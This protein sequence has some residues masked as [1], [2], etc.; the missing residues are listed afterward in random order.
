MKWYLKCLRQFANFRGRARRKEFWMF[1]LFNV[2]ITLLYLLLNDL[3]S[4]FLEDTK[5]GV[6]LFDILRIIYLAYLVV[7]FT[8]SLAVT[9]RRLHDVGKSGW[10]ILIIL[11]PIYGFGWLVH[12]LFKYSDGENKYGQPYWKY[13]E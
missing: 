8:P 9:F 7:V 6:I 4:R 11:I 13:E 3:T 2:I 10:F 12:L 1:M 5:V